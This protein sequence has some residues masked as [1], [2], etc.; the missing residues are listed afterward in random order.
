MILSLAKTAYKNKLKD[1]LIWCSN[2]YLGMSR[3]V[4]H[5]KAECLDSYG[6][7]SG[8]TRNISGTHS[9]LVKLEDDLAN[10]IVNKKP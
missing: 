9:P 6:I 4:I 1:I 3:N 7:G 5:K 8:G 2:D 10:F